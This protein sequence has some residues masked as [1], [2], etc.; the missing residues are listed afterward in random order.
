MIVAIMYC[1]LAYDKGKINT[2]LC[3]GIVNFY[4]EFLLIFF[5]RGAVTALTLGVL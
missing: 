1:H 3:I 4:G 2:Q 5:Y